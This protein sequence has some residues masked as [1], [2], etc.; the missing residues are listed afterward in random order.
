MSNKSKRNEFIGPLMVMVRG[1]AFSVLARGFEKGIVFE[2]CENTFVVF[3]FNY[4]ESHTSTQWKNNAGKVIP[5]PEGVEDDAVKTLARV[6]FLF[7]RQHKTVL[8]RQ[9]RQG[10]SS[11]IEAFY[12]GTDFLL[13][14]LNYKSPG[15]KEAPCLVSP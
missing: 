5:Q 13:S 2:G 8:Q 6:A 7:A 11:R 1:E 14:C 15:R 4:D 12:E 10:I 3:S 9:A